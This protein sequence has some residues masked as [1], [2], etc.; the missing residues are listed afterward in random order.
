MHQIEN[1]NVSMNRS[2]L[3]CMHTLEEIV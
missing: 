1:S 3:Y 2:I